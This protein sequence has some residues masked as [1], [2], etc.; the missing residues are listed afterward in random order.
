[1][2][3]QGLLVRDTDNSNLEL[4]PLNVHLQL[5]GRSPEFSE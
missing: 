3:R 5:T 1:M 4:E 2:V